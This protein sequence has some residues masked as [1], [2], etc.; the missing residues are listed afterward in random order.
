MG[1][2]T[3]LITETLIVKE[4][5]YWVVFAAMNVLHF[6]PNYLLNFRNSSFFPYWSEW[7]RSRRIGLIDSPNQD[8]F[9]YTVEF[10]LLLLLARVLYLRPVVPLMIVMYS[11]LL[12]FNWYQYLFRRIYETEPNFYNDGK[13]LKNG[14]AIVWDESPWKVLLALVGLVGLFGGLHIALAWYIDFAYMTG[15]APG[16][17]V[18]GGL[19][20][21]MLSRS[22]LLTGV[23]RKYPN[24]VYNRFHFTIV[25]IG[26]NI[27]RSLDTRRI[28]RRR[29]GEVFRA[30]REPLRLTLKPNP[31]NIHLHFIESYGS[32]LFVEEKVRDRGYAMFSQFQKQLD[33][34][35]WSVTSN[36]S[37]SPTTGG[38][39]W[40]TYSSMLYGMRIADN[41]H[42]ENYLRDEDFN[43]SNS[44]LRLLQTAGY[45]NYNLNPISPIRG[46][47]VPYEEMR[48][49]Y[50][51]DRWLL[52][53]DLHYTGDVYGFG[54]CPPDQYCLNYTMDLIREEAKAP[55][56]LFY[57]TKN[58]HSPFIPPKMAEDWRTLNHKDGQAHIHRGFLAQPTDDDYINAIQYQFDNLSDFISRHGQHE[59]IFLIIGDHQPPILADTERHGR[60]TP[61]HVVSKNRAFLHDWE[62]YGFSQGIE[63]CQQF[64][65]HEGLYSIFLR[66]FGAHYAQ[67]D[68]I[69]P[70]YEPDGLQL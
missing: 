22:L 46:I 16:L 25:E 23:Y 35:R 54:E 9:R 27:E 58:S 69:L 30:A 29:I 67:P 40:L 64:V 50:S 57:L 32:Y 19:W 66:T 11:F 26:K 68:S 4:I 18:V 37:A 49:F 36:F 34:N 3:E 31:P 55:Y 53:D 45:T 52:K 41:T 24:D 33:A 10:S 5:I 17:Y 28:A 44:I 51:I 21:A 2:I 13:L 1:N 61:V 6:L 12:L 70:T 38:Q 15:D 20:L 48:T 7:V 60:T 47:N 59:D 42:F 14:W 56:V 8:P 62:V 63:D 65:S 43:S 39:S